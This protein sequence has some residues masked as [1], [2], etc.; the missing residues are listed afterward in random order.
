[1]ALARLM[2]RSI[3]FIQVDWPLYG[4]KLAQVAIAYGANDIDGIAALTSRHSAR[5]DRRARTSN[6]RFAPSCDARGAEW[7]V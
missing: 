3:P 4:P 5:A 7:T 2:C 1:M 6:A